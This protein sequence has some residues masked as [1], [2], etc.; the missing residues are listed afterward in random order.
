LD[1][2]KYILL[3]ID[4][5]EFDLPL[6]Y[7]LF[8]SVNEQMSITNQGL[9][10]VNHLLDEY[11]IK[12][13]FF[14]TS[15]YARAN[16]SIIREIGTKHEIASHSYSHSIFDHGDFEKSKQVLEE[17]SQNQVKGF[18]MPRLAE[19]D[20]KELK[21]CGY[22]YDSSLNPTYIPFRYNHFFKPRSLFFETVTNLAIIP[23]SVSPII[24]FPLF[25]LSFKNIPF[26]IYTFLCKQALNK[27]KYLHLYF[28]SWEFAKIKSFNIPAYVKRQDADLLT[29]RLE[30]LLVYLKKKG[31]FVTVSEFLEIKG[32]K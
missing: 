1:A 16:P 8:L 29:A 25:W 11:N 3:T 23:V 28:H 13:T 2:Y 19:V 17:I 18:R 32:Y 9:I 5:E 24:R 31:K 14:I 10:K 4:L 12:A 20:Y 21:R 26:A 7:G 27:D 22:L 6:E 30:K 15:T